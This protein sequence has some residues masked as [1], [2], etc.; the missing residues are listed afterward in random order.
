MKALKI[1]AKINCLCLSVAW[2]CAGLA[3]VL[4]FT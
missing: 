2:F 1:A 3:L 4:A